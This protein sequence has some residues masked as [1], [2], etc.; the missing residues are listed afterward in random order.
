M[1]F[2][3]PRTASTQ[4]RRP[5]SR[6]CD[7]GVFAGG[8]IIRTRRSVPYVTV[9]TGH[10]TGASCGYSD[11]SAKKSNSFVVLDATVVVDVADAEPPAGVD[12]DRHAAER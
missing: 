7:T 12:F 1:N 11:M 6:R 9:D 8:L 5:T 3:S 2:P 4:S 10:S